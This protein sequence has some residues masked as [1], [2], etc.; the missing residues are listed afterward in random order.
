MIESFVGTPKSKVKLENEIHN[1]NSGL[2]LINLNEPKT[3]RLRQ[4]WKTIK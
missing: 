4:F 3:I 1:L 2:G